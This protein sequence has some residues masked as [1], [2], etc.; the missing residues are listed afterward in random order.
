MNAADVMAQPVVTVMPD[1]RPGASQGARHRAARRPIAAFV[2]SNQTLEEDYIRSHATKASDIMRRNVISAAPSASL[3]D[4]VDLLEKHR[5]K[6]IPIVENGKLVGIVSRADLVR[7]LAAVEPSPTPVHASDKQIRRQLMAELARYRWG[8]AHGNS[9]TVRHGIVHLWGV[10]EA[11]TE[12]GAIRVAAEAI[13]GV[14]GVQDHTAV[15]PV[16]AMG[17]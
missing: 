13:P 8:R 7:A 12:I 1:R 5:I 2:A 3:S 14:R 11:S 17:G 10:V 9:V 16:V 6:R 4:I 15:A